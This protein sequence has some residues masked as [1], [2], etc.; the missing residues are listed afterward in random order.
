MTE[1][2]Q[3]FIVGMIVGA[4]SVSVITTLLLLRQR[5]KM[6]ALA[7]EL[8]N[9]SF[10][11]QITLNELAEKNQ[12]LQQQSWLDT[13]SNAY[14]RSYFEQQMA[15][16]INRSRREQHP[17]ALVFIDVD[18][19]KDIND[20]YG[21]LVGDQVIKNLV[22]LIQ[23]QLK[24]ASDK[25]CRFGG[26]EFAII[27]PNTDLAGAINLAESIRQQLN[28]APLVEHE[29]TLT[30]TISAGCYTATAD[31]SS[32]INDYIGHADKALYQSKTQGRNQVSAQ[33]SHT[34]ESSLPG[35]IHEH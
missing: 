21:H 31:S 28:I 1:F 22:S 18:R 5:Q 33:C 32:C 25:L 30:V 11:L 35:V 29:P 26:D 24:R 4:V 20:D 19:F 10:E 34:A 23:Q 13:L 2:W 7:T 3:H 9:H 8:R 12:L 27:L 6:A 15:A 14:N 16:E 17:L